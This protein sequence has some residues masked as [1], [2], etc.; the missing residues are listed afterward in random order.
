MALGPSAGRAAATF[1]GTNG[2]LAVFFRAPVGDTD[3]DTALALIGADGRVDDRFLASPLSS[4]DSAGSARF[5]PDGRRI[6]F[7]STTWRGDRV[8]VAPINGYGPHCLAHGTAPAWTPNGRRLI[9]IHPD[10]SRYWYEIESIPANGG[11]PQVLA[12]NA[13]R[14][15]VGVSVTGKIAFTGSN[16]KI[17][18][19]NANGTGLR[20]LTTGL[21][22]SPTTGAGLDYSPSWSPD[23]RRLAFERYDLELFHVLIVRVRDGATRSIA[24]SGRA[25]VWSPDGRLIVYE[26][27]S[28]LRLVHPYGTGGRH[29]KVSPAQ[30]SFPSAPT[31]EPDSKAPADWQAL[32]TGR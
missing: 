24:G 32:N 8:C 16:G 14:D 30:P 7:T 3:A 21:L 20:Q 31:F 23:G 4:I 26:R 29:L 2:K 27:G 15:E 13:E 25:P 9:Y 18:V 12:M 5:S 28:G 19:M 22:P 1:P 11:T 10:P 6:A 17:W